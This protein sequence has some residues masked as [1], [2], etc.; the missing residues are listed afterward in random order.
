MRTGIKIK[1]GF[2]PLAFILFLCTPVIEINGGK[3]KR[4]WGTYFFDLTPG[5]HIVKIYFHYWLKPECGVNQI[6]VSIAEGQTKRI[7]YFMPP[8]M[9]AAGIIKEVKYK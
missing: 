2:F 7:T 5:D 1:T 9:L 6:K 4:H 3:F 8:W